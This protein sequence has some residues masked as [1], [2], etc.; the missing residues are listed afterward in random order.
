VFSI[1]VLPEMSI[2]QS[3]EGKKTG[4]MS[5]KIQYFLK[6]DARNMMNLFAY[7]TVP[8][9]IKLEAWSCA[10]VKKLGWIMRKCQCS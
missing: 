3:F 9:L 7:I 10:L 5:G 1:A 2:I 4:K 6:A 8:P